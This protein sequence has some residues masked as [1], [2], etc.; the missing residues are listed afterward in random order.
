MAKSGGKILFGF[1]F[2]VVLTGAL[3]GGGAWYLTE[4]RTEG[5]RATATLLVTP[6]ENGVGAMVPT[7]NSSAPEGLHNAL[8]VTPRATAIAPPDYAT[9]FT[10]DEM[11]NALRERL[12]VEMPLEAVRAA[13]NAETQVALQTRNNVVYRRTIALHFTADTP[14]LAEKGANGWAAIAQEQAVEWQAKDQQ[15]RKAALQDRLF[16]L[17]TELEKARA[18]EA[19]LPQAAS[20]EPLEASARSQRAAT[21][22]MKDDLR[23]MEQA[24]ARDEA[25][26]STLKSYISKAP[27]AVVLELSV[28]EADLEAT[29]AGTRAERDYLAAQVAALAPE[30]VETP[31]TGPETRHQ[32]ESVQ[33]SIARL[34][35][36]IDAA[37]NALLA[38][39]TPESAVQLAAL[40]VTPETPMG[41]HRYVLVGGAAA[42]GAILGMILYFGLLTLRVYARDLD[43][44]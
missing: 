31:N 16:Q 17:F 24:L 36:Q 11:A 6:T 40:A 41:P 42:L 20:E 32:L 18:R 22:R 44:P 9:L 33:A 25:A 39:G 10:T 23:A 38:M 34:R 28:K 3:A 4:S 21:Q 27:V 19:A 26:L 15:S 14:E 12:G 7:G 1:L 13:M 8:G 37:E 30:S 29:L 5:Y 43:R 2:F 35:P